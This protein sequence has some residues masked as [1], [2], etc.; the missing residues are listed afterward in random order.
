[1]KN[2]QNQKNKNC[3]KGCGKN[4][5]GKNGEGHEYKRGGNND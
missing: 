3:S 4:C 5:G 1:M 2:K